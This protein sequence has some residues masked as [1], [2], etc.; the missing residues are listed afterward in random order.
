MNFNDF[1][2]EML[3]RGSV[4]SQTESRTA[5]I[6]FDILTGGDHFQQDRHAAEEDLKL[7]RNEL[8]NR[9]AELETIK[10]QIVTERTTLTGA[11]AKQDETL[12]A[13]N[14]ELIEFQRRLLEAETP[15]ARDKLRLAEYYKQTL[16]FERDKDFTVGLSRILAAWSNTKKSDGGRE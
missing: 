15:E 16:R 11:R 5:A 3:R 9:T 2:M 1:K 12:K 7:L 13:R 6:A 10:R 14:E 4:K 8:T